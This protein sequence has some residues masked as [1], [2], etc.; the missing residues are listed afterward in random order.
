[1]TLRTRPIE[2][3]NL[4]TLCVAGHEVRRVRRFG[5]VAALRAAKGLAGVGATVWLILV[6]TPIYFMVITSVRTSD[7]YVG[8]GA[9]RPPSDLTAENYGRVLDLGF[10]RFLLNSA[11]VT[12]TTVVLVLVMALPAGY[13]IVRGRSR[14]ARLAFTLFLLGLA[15]PAQAVVIPLYLVITRLHLYDSLT[16]VVLPTVAFSLPVAIVV[17]TSYLRDI[18]KELYESMVA[19]GASAGS[20]F[21]RL[22]VPAARPALA[23]VGIYSGLNAWNG[24]IFPLVLTQSEQR[25][26]VPLGLWNFQS[27][28]GTDVPGLFAAVLLSTV[29]VLALYLF[30]RRQLLRGLSAGYGR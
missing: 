5:P 28:Y 16:A 17:F 21:F 7:A 6:A 22:V 4:A 19:D 13:S 9:L 2:S 8:E 23:T 29:P 24:F 25:Q 18:P 14:A 15:I 3:T 30:G 10:G 26:V 27:Q 11:I 1:V 20:V 12:V